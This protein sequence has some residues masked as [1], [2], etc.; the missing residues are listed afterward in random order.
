[1]AISEDQDMDPY[2]VPGSEY[3]FELKS[4]DLEST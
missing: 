1:M 4:P 2:P 3:K